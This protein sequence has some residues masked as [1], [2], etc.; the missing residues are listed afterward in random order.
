MVRGLALIGFGL[1]G[2]RPVGS[3]PGLA[4]GS[5]SPLCPT[6]GHQPCF[7]F[8]EL[9]ILPTGWRECASTWHPAQ[10]LLIMGP[11]T[12]S[13]VTHRGGC[14]DAYPS[15]A[16]LH[17]GS[18]DPGALISGPPITG[19]HGCPSAVLRISHEEICGS[20]FILTKDIPSEPRGGRESYTPFSLIAS[21]RSGETDLGS[22][23]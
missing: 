16:G 7:H 21:Y 13:S 12:C 5:H 1:G 3:M 18:C 22:L 10:S 4:A 9:L 6:H 19:T 17:H 2:Q 8:L 23:I 20:V 11:R 15:H 14:P